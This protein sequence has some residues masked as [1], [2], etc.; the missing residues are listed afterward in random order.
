MRFQL[1][2][3]ELQALCPTKYSYPADKKKLEKNSQQSSK[4]RGYQTG[5]PAVGP[6]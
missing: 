1:V 5:N 4:L 6:S 3:P 2:T